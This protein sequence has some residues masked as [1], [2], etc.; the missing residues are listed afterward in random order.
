VQQPPE[1]LPVMMQSVAAFVFGR[2]DHGNHFTLNSVQRALA[3]HQLPVQIIMQPH[4]AAVDA[5][6][7]EDIVPVRDNILGRNSILGDIIDECHLLFLMLKE[8]LNFSDYSTIKVV[9]PKLF[10]NPGKIKHK[11]AMVS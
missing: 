7:P 11:M 8:I 4:R 9:L 1:T 10:I 3:V 2:Y 5:M 6:D